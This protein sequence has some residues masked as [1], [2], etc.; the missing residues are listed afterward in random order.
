MPYHCKITF[1]FEKNKGFKIFIWQQSE[2][3]RIALNGY[4]YLT[5]GSEW[6][7]WTGLESGSGTGE[8]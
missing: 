4:A 2:T 8:W 7:V 3:S 1:F 6:Y 5:H